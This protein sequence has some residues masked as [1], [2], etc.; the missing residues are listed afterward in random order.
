MII[1]GVNKN[2]LKGEEKDELEKEC[3]YGLIEEE[4][5]KWKIY[6]WNGNLYCESII[7]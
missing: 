7:Y 2:T 6:Y 1:F 3:L 5:K 4:R